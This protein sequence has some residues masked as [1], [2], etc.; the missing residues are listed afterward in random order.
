M[1][2]CMQKR[3]DS[4]LFGGRSAAFEKKKTDVLI[5]E[6]ERVSW[7]TKEKRWLVELASDRLEE[8]VEEKVITE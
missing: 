3:V 8:K 1:H 5:T 6:E 4:A 7:C 2:S